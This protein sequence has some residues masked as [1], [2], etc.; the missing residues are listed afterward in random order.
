MEIYFPVSKYMDRV[1]KALAKLTPRERERVK[2]I[3]E[4]IS[5]GAAQG[6]NIKK[7]KGREDIFRVRKGGIRIIYRSIKTKIFILAIGRRSEKTYR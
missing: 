2:E 3:L 1:E 4:K 6:L 5:T 7:L